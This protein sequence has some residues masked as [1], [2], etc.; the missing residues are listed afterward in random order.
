MCLPYFQG[1]LSCKIG[2][3]T[4][5][6]KEKKLW[7]I[8]KLIEFKLETGCAFPAKVSKTTLIKTTAQLVKK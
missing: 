7:F 8:S 3:V 5:E 6:I 4:F 2:I 1:I